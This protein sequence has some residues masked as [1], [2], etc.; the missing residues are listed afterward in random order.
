MHTDS[1]L[2]ADD[3][4]FNYGVS[5]G[6]EIDEN[7]D[8]QLGYTHAQASEESGNYSGGRYRQNLLGVDALYFFSRDKF[9]PFVLAG[10]GVAHNSLHYSGIAPTANSSGS[11][12][13][14]MG[15][16][17][18][19]AQYMFTESLGMQADIRQVYSKVNAGGGLFGSD[20]NNNVGNTYLN[21]GVIFKFGEPVHTA[22]AE[23][24]KKIV[25]QKPAPLPAL[26]PMPKPKPNPEPEPMA[27]VEPKPEPL[28][29]IVG[30]DEAAFPKVSV[31]AEV[32]FDF[33]K[34]NIKPEGKKIL[35][36]Q[37]VEKMKANSQV[38][39]LLITGHADRLGREKFNQNLSEQRAQSVK[40]Y[41]IEQGIENSRLHAVGKGETEP[42]VECHDSKRSKLIQCLQPS[43][44]V[45]LEIE[46]QRA[47]AK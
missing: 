22:A 37:V 9:R 40:N 11:Q 47:T 46:A 36:E 4:N 1:N 38:E 15:N 25:S 30:P 5:V 19:G 7:W 41:L 12:Y 17:G 6:K 43:R 13:S 21:L 35:E 29:E 18:A 24:M 44:R 8:V 45:V 14:W 31:Q 16:V 10:L 28:P 26:Q 34:A 23:P 42:A 20:S 27:K 33:D 2:Q 39:L 3:N 32:L